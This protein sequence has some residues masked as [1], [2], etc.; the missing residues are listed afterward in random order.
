MRPALLLSLLVCSLSTG[1]VTAATDV[2]HPDGKLPTD[3]LQVG[4]RPQ[5]V[6]VA[7][8]KFRP[9]IR[10]ELKSKLTARKWAIPFMK[11]FFVASMHQVKS[12]GY[13]YLLATSED[14]E[15]V[16]DYVGWVPGRY[17]VPRPEAVIDPDTGIVK[18]A[19]IVNTLESLGTKLNEVMIR[20]APQPRAVG[21]DEPQRLYTTLFVYGEADNYVLVGEATSFNS[22]KDE[23][24]RKVVLGWL[25]RHKIAIWN[26]R[27][28]LEWDYPS[29]LEPKDRPRSMLKFPYYLNKVKRPLG[30]ARRTVVG[31]IYATP[32]KARAGL[33]DDSDKGIFEEELIHD[34]KLGYDVSR[35][36][37]PDMPRFPVL[38]R[39][40]AH[41][42]VAGD[43]FEV[44]GIGGLCDAKGRLLLG[45]HEVKKLQEVLG[46]LRNQASQT[47]ILFVIDDTESMDTWFPV[48]ARTVRAITSA[49]RK[50]GRRVRVAV[51]F[52][53]DVTKG[54][55]KPPVS[56]SPLR[57]VRTS[58]ERIAQ[59]VEK[60]ERGFGGDPHEMVFRGIIEGI[61]AAKFSSRARK[62]VV[63]IGDCG[64]IS[65]SKGRVKSDKEYMKRYRLEGILDRLVP[66]NLASEA[67]IEFYAVQVIDPTDN[68][69][70]GDFKKQMQQI[71]EEY[72]KRLRAR[73]RKLLGKAFDP[74]SFRA[75]AGY[76]NRVENR[77]TS[78]EGVLAAQY[79]RLLA[80]AR[81]LEEM[82]GRLQK[83]QWERTRLTPEMEQM[84]NRDLARRGLKVTLEELRNSGGLQLF[85]PGYV[86]ER[87]RTGQPLVRKRVF[88]NGE[89][90]RELVLFLGQ[91]DTRSGADTSLAELLAG[92]IE[93]QAN[94]GDRNDPE[95]L[96]RL[97]IRDVLK[98]ATGL[99]FRNSLMRK[100][101][102][103]LKGKRG[104]LQDSEYFKLLH[105]RDL[106]KDVLEGKTF[107]YERVKRKRAGLLI[108]DYE[109]KGKPREQERG[110]TIGNDK[111]VRWYYLDYEKEW[112]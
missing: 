54:S 75:P 86:W 44:G 109:R 11:P 24:A 91:L 92:I 16:K 49:A 94:T 46:L 110:F 32:A 1:F 82:L 27:E 62:L 9:R 98:Q 77:A 95:R 26:T 51:S 29:T 102:D 6:W 72:G 81:I 14:G 47:D 66:T 34:D 37:D 68:V 5:L 28:A 60:H 59:A 97:S 104:E 78:V 63:V 42:P 67:P 111:A 61:D 21:K 93:K 50:D 33:K 87:T 7:Y 90:L 79:S 107:Q 36:L 85:Q 2:K 30:P 55:K 52:Y 35:P 22:R 89:E 48:V 39:S 23:D 57:D 13:S 74:K 112:P 101:Y 106:L 108:D 100:T 76:F 56:A 64:D 18:K 38:Q 10:P 58:G 105:S 25:P 17:L 31:R 12:E 19:L 71:V 3:I 8:E 99:A 96:K 70:A 15:K 83:G 43:L 40:V 45:S 65:A 69:A 20:H 103:D 80:E 84:I 73:K 88:I 41:H 4:R 53:N